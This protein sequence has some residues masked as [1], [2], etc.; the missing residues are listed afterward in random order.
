MAEVSALRLLLVLTT[1]T[2]KCFDFCFNDESN[3]DTKRMEKITV[4]NPLIVEVLVVL[5]YPVSIASLLNIVHRV[6][7]LIRYR[8]PTEQTAGGVR[9]INS[10]SSHR[11]CPNIDTASWY[12]YASCISLPSSQQACTAVPDRAPYS[13]SRSL[14]A[15]CMR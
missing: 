14:F 4:V 11:V 6:L 7:H 2:V 10:G 5:D 1:V 8:L 12:R 3:S 15:M 13:C 9:Y